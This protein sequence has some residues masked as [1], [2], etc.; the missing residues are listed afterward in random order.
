MPSAIKKA[1]IHDQITAQKVMEVAEKVLRLRWG[2]EKS[3]FITFVKFN[4][5]TL[6]ISSDSPAAMQTLKVETVDLINSINR[7]LGQRAVLSIQL[8]KRG[9]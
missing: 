3:A 2:N 1:G 8:S 5:G 7:E 6:T 9:Y 4:K